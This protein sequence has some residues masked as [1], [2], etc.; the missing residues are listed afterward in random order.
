MGLIGAAGYFTQA[1]L[2]TNGQGGP[3]DSTRFFSL[4]LFQNAFMYFRM[5]YASAMAWLL[6]III[7]TLTL[8]QF[9]LAPKWVH[10][11]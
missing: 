6:F 5:G 1:F 7:M 2:M 10:Y 3:V 8:L 9:K 4:Y 11:Q